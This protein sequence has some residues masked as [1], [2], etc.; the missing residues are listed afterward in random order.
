MKDNRIRTLFPSVLVAV[1]MV[2]VLG[3]AGQTG[4][5]QSAPASQ[6]NLFKEVMAKKDTIVW[7]NAPDNL[8]P[9]Q[10]C[11]LLQACAGSPDKFIATPAV[12]ENGQQVARGLFLTK[13]QDPKHGDAVMLLDQ[14][15]DLYLFLVSPDGNLQKAAYRETGKSWLVISNSLAQPIFDKDKKIWHDRVAKLGGAP[16]ASAKPEGATAQ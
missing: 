12:T 3:L 4:F 15:L 13:T 6:Y 14:S 9:A 16:P 11:T 10:A 7:K 2:S 5:A 1:V 8:L